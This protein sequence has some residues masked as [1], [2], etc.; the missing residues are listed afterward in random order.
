MLRDVRGGHLR[1]QFLA[2]WITSLLKLLIDEPFKNAKSMDFLVSGGRQV[3][4]AII[5]QL[6]CMF[7]CDMRF[8]TRLVELECDGIVMLYV[9]CPLMFRFVRPFFET[10]LQ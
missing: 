6:S 1:V 3:L 7:G 10:L 8:A 4:C 9:A 2:D 5:G